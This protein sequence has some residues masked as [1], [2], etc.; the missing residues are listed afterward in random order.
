MNGADPSCAGQSGREI[1]PLR[2]G[3]LPRL[4]NG[5]AIA[6]GWQNVTAFGGARGNP[7]YA[8]TERVLLAR[9]CRRRVFAYRR[10]C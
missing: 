1:P 8:L 7:D 3:A 9:S 10:D 4:P 5:L 6:S 2:T